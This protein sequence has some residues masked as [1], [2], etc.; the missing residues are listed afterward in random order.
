MTYTYM[1]REGKEV[2]TKRV[3]LFLLANLKNIITFLPRCNR[4]I[5]QYSTTCVTTLSFNAHTPI[6][7]TTLPLSLSLSLPLYLSR[8]HTYI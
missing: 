7:T 1:L 3:K 6:N 2:N 4:K 8:I 5:P